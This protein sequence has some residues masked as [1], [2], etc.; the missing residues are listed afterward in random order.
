MHSYANQLSNHLFNANIQ[1]FNKNNLWSL[2][3]VQHAARRARTGAYHALNILQ[4][5]YVCICTQNAS[6]PFTLYRTTEKRKFHRTFTNG[7]S[8]TR[9][10]VAMASMQ[11]YSLSHPVQLSDGKFF[12]INLE[13]AETLYSGLRTDNVSLLSLDAIN[14]FFRFRPK[15]LPAQH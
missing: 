12:S 10:A 14:N 15:K 5:A 2:R 7:M 9:R 8:A 13:N 6:V 3:L 1:L 11:R 4:S